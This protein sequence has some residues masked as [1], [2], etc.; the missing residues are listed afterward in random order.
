[1]DDLDRF[2]PVH[3]DGTECAH[4]GA[5]RLDSP[6]GPALCPAGQRVTGVLFGGRVVE[7]GTAMTVIQDIGRQI[8]AAQSP[9]VQAL[10]AWAWRLDGG[11]MAV[12]RLV[13]LGDI[14][15]EHGAR[16]AGHAP[17][18]Y[19][20][21]ELT[22]MRDKGTVTSPSWVRL[23]EDNAAPPAAPDW[24]PVMPGWRPPPPG[25][26]PA[27]PPMDPSGDP[28]VSGGQIGV[29]SEPYPGAV[30]LPF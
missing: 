25:V 3:D 15:A 6:H 10:A 20:V 19:T 24:S 1:M 21:A 28:P 8:A 9:L 4:P 11:D 30:P 29:P 5:P 7:L 16:A 14:M 22:A 23:E 17:A 13:T 2:A 27:A 18:P 12:R 26:L